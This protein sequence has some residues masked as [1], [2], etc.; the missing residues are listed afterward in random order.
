MAEE[1][2]ANKTLLMTQSAFMLSTLVISG[3]VKIPT[4]WGIPFTLQTLI[5]LLCSLILPF[6]A[7]TLTIGTF[8]MGGA[9]GLPIF[10][11]GA[12][13]FTYLAGPTGGFLAGFI[14][15]PLVVNIIS[16]FSPKSLSG[17]RLLAAATCGMIPIYLLGV[18]WM[19]YGTG[20]PVKK[21]FYG[22]VLPF[23][24][25]AFIKI[26]LAVILFEELKKRSVL[27]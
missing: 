20:L 7:A 25:A 19:V 23:L 13:G 8:L 26:A 21:A 15:V 3:Y 4:P 9:I 2:F 18:W 1:K 5:L 27:S 12:G 10:A 16:G 14:L 17:G 24:P 6:K 11:G 22:G